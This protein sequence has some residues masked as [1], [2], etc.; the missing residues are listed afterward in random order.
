[1][2]STFGGLVKADY[3]VIIK[4]CS[5][6]TKCKNENVTLIESVMHLAIQALSLASLQA[7]HWNKGD[8]YFK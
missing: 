8:K 3:L 5:L 2:F 1:M 7:C 4:C 6:F